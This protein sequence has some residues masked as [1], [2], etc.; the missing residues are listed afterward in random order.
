MAKITQKE[1]SQLA[2]GERAAALRKK[3]AD[4]QQRPIG[5]KPAAMG[6]PISFTMNDKAA[7]DAYD[8][9]QNQREEEAEVEEKRAKGYA[10][11]GKIRTTKGWGIAR[12]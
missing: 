5:G 2:A 1:A 12:R 11:G 4:V 7:S 10:K 9:R 3:I 8:A 6:E